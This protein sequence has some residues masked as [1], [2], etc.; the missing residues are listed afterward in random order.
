[1]SLKASSFFPLTSISQKYIVALSGAF[2]HFFVLVHMLGNLLI[3]VGAEVYNAYSHKLISNPVTPFFE[4]ALLLTFLVHLGLASRLN[5]KNKKARAHPYKVLD[6]GEK[7]TSL[8]RRT[9]WHQG[10]VIF[11]FVVLHIVAFKYGTYYEFQLGDEKVRDLYRLVME[12]FQNPF[13]VLWYIVAISILGFHLGHGFSAW[14]QSLGFYREESMTW[15]RRVGNIYSFLV[16]VGFN[17][18]PLFCYFF[19]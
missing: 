17:A 16:V 4:I 19:L 6:Y 3:F 13:I 5:Y 2:L 15:I 10:V 7:G 12:V 8:I 14:I 11:V 18:I 9:L 1:M